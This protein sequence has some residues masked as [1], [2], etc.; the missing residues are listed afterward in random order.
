MT[1]LYVT[2][3][4]QFSCTGIMRYLINHFDRLQRSTF[5]SLCI[6]VFISL[7]ALN[8]SKCVSSA[9]YRVEGNLVA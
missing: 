2:K 9:E 4:C 3:S 7:V 8:T 5:R 1:T 6:Y